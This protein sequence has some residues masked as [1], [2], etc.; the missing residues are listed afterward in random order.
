MDNKEIL[1]EI[2]LEDGIED[3]SFGD[4]SFVVKYGDILNTDTEGNEYYLLDTYLE[5]PYSFE[6][7]NIKLHRGI[8]D[9]LECISVNPYRYSGFVHYNTEDRKFC[10]GSCGVPNTCVDIRADG[11]NSDNFNK[12]LLQF[13]TYLSN[14]SH[15]TTGGWKKLDLGTEVEDVN[16]T[17][18][19]SIT[20]DGIKFPQVIKKVIKNTNTESIDYTQDYEVLAEITDRKF[21]YNNETIIPKVVKHQTVQVVKDVEEFLGVNLNDIMRIIKEKTIKKYKDE[22]NSQPT[23]TT[24]DFLHKLSNQHSGVD[25]SFYI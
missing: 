20:I 3:V 18:H 19:K 7:V 4:Q 16:F 21:V 2:V 23:Y 10:Y 5:I 24:E 11:L 13:H 1:R 17:V 22:I 9:V 25:G 12:L 8:V 14:S 6:S 15:G